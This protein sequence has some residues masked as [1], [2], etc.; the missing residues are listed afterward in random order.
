MGERVSGYIVLDCCLGL[1]PWQV[2]NLLPEVQASISWVDINWVTILPFCLFSRSSPWHLEGH[3]KHMARLCQTILSSLEFVQTAF[4]STGGWG[5][6]LDPSYHTKHGTCCTSILQSG[7]NSSIHVTAPD[8]PW[9]S[10]S[11]LLKYTG[12][13]IIQTRMRLNIFQILE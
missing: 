5:Q 13:L 10:L 3:S 4:P 9:G 11:F 6:C 2:Q 1:K 12:N 8:F 7:W